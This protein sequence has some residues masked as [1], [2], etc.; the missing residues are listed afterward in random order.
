M[1]TPPRRTSARSGSTS[2]T[3]SP[4]SGCSLTWSPTLRSLPLG[5]DPVGAVDVAADQVL[6]RVV[7]VEA[8]PPLPEL[9]DPGPDLVGCGRHGDGPG[10]QEIGIGDEVIAGEDGVAFLVGRPPS[11]LPPPD[12]QNVGRYRGAD[13][14]SARGSCSTPHPIPPTVAHHHDVF[15][16]ASDRPAALT[17]FLV[18]K[19]G[20]RGPSTSRSGTP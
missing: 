2:A 11:Q 3:A 14:G 13:D 17:H 1:G 5:H 19:P 15:F 7:A 10:C 8:A 4:T 18:S 9:H 6:Q 16:Q 12:Q 20:R